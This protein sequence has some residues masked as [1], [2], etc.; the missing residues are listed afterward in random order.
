[1][2]QPLEGMNR[3]SPVASETGFVTLLTTREISLP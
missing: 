3:V 1:M 2:R